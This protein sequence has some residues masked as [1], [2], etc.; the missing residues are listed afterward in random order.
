MS[1]FFQDDDQQSTSYADDSTP[2]DTEE[3]GAPEGESGNRLFLW[4]AIGL[5]VL[6]LASLICGAVFL[7][8]R[9]F[10]GNTNTGALSEAT[11][12][13]Q[14]QVALAVEQTRQV[15]NA[16]PTPLPTATATVP[17]SA[18]PLMVT[19][20]VET[21]GVVDSLAETATVAF[22]NTQV[23]AQGTTGASGGA[24]QQ[25]AAT[26]RTQGGATVQPAA[27][28]ASSAQT[29]AAK[30]TGTPRTMPNSGFADEVGLPALFIA[31][32]VMMAIIFLARRLRSSTLAR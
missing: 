3:G 17:P 19:V 4:G 22:L 18:T 26:N 9:F 16:T 1:A 14:T 6:V 27:T 25:P 30:T 7:L 2:A 23:A 20:A 32:M 29:A 15:L 5:G 13:A 31:A 8:P 11:S 21:P 24:T 28:N 12:A 10:G